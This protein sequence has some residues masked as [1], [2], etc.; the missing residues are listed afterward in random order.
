VPRLGKLQRQ[1]FF[2]FDQVL[3]EQR[4]ELADDERLALLFR[5]EAFPRFLEILLLLGLF[6]CGL[7]SRGRLIAAAAST[8]RG[9]GQQKENDHMPVEGVRIAGA[10]QST[11]INPHTLFLRDANL[12][13][14]TNDSS[15]SLAPVHA[16][17]D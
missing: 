8:E 6:R 14:C 13:S 11:A 17:A 9:Q 4:R 16:Q 3:A 2:G 1:A 10:R 15:E 12:Y 7:L 5:F